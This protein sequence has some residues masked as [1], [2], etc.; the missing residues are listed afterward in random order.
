MRTVHPIQCNSKPIDIGNLLNPEL[1]Y[2]Y[3]LPT[4]FREVM[5]K[6]T[7][8]LL[9]VLEILVIAIFP[10]KA[11]KLGNKKSCKQNDN[12]HKNYKRIHRETL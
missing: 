9:V 12:I 2:Q 5:L 7:N 3:F 4:K 8:I 6:P 10:P 11:S 1:K